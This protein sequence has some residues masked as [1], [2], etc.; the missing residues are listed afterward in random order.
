MEAWPVTP[1]AGAQPGKLSPADGSGPGQVT[2]RQTG[3]L[4]PTPGRVALVTGAARGIGQAIAAGLAER[5]TRI[6]HGDIAD[7]SETSDL[8]GATGHPGATAT[9]R[10]RSVL[11]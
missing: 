3:P 6:V 8:T 1:D 2:R 9:P 11:D 5:A 10:Q 7:V 4:N